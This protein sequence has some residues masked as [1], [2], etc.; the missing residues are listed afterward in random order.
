MGAAAAIA[1]QLGGTHQ[2]H[3]W[4]CLCPL[5][6]GYVMSL[7]DGEDGRLLAFCFGGC[8]FD[9]V[10]SALVGYGLL[11]DLD[12]CDDSD[13]PL[14]PRPAAERIAHAAERVAQAREIYAGGVEDERVQIYLRSRGIKLTSPVLRFSEHPPHRL[15]AHLPAMLAPVV[16][17]SGEQTGVHMT[18][19][20]HDGG[21]KADLP[22]EFQRECR[23]VIRGGAIRLCEHD[24]YSE[25]II[26]EGIE[27]TFAAAGLFG[28][29]SRSAV[30][31]AIETGLITTQL[32]LPCWS[33]VFAG[34]LKT[35]ELP[36]D[37][38][39]IIIAADNDASGAGQRNALAAY[40]RW[41]AEGREVRIKAP[42]DV[43]DDFNDVL[44]KRRP[45]AQH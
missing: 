30:F 17:I 18:Y 33:A 22:E 34:G 15:G 21:G 28:R 29:V 9:Q 1:R 38:R 12:D 11:D 40:D 32:A 45:D 4:R 26:G 43:G 20:R 35:L 14:T 7:S 10:M 42:P 44:I 23:G 8:E 31:A 5:D 13:N 3:N 24:P 2:G 6:C 25:L 19:L 27:T 16:N 37:V 41:T 39:R 36:P